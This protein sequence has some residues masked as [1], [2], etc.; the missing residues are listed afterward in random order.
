AATGRMTDMNRTLEIKRGSKLGDVRRIGIHLV[1][2][3]RLGRAAMPTTVVRDHP[4]AL[5]EEE[6]HLVVPVVR[7]Q[8]PAMV[9]HNRLRALGTPVLVEDLGPVL[10]G[11]CAHQPILACLALVR[12]WSTSGVTKTLRSGFPRA[13]NI[14]AD[15]HAMLI[16]IEE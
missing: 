12:T 15:W 5:L 10:R 7:A 3:V 16:S 2:G 1:S 14:M 8:R 11:D 4:I 9:E 13:G 6:H